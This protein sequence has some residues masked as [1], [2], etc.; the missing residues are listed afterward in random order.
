MKT[1]I[2]YV[3]VGPGGGNGPMVEDVNHLSL[4][5]DFFQDFFGGCGD[6]NVKLEEFVHVFL[7][8]VKLE[9]TKFQQS[10]KS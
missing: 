8:I 6:F 4:K 7:L 5:D 9:P 2:A 1:H 3:E 10:S